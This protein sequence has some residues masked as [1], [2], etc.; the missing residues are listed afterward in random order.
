MKR[1]NDRS[2]RARVTGWHGALLGALSGCNALLG[3]EAGYL[4]GD[5]EVSVEFTDAAAKGDSG[6]GPTADAGGAG[7][8]ASTATDGRE[9]TTDLVDAGTSTQATSTTSD[10]V[11]SSP[12]KSSGSCASDVTAEACPDAEC[13][14]GTEELRSLAC[15]CGDTGEQ[16]RRCQ[17]DCSWSEWTELAACSIGCCSQVVFCNTQENA[18]A[19]AQFPNRGTWCRRTNPDCS[20]AQVRTDCENDAKD[21]NVCGGIIEEFFI[22]D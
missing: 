7:G 18:A 6:G 17:E 5:A 20:S 8:E 21:P 11:T 22:E 2:R 10:S 9:T 3:N 12:C 19:A 16:A 13:V 14:P 15:A 1:A 4:I